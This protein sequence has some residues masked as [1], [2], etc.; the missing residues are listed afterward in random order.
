[1]G[2]Y[3]ARHLEALRNF[4][5]YSRRQQQQVHTL[6]ARSQQVRG[7]CWRG[8]QKYCLPLCV[9]DIS[10]VPNVPSASIPRWEERC[11]YVDILPRI[12]MQLGGKWGQKAGY[13]AFISR[14][15][16][17]CRRPYIWGLAPLQLPNAL[18][19]PRALCAGGRVMEMDNQGMTATSSPLPSSDH[20]ARPWRA[21]RTCLSAVVESA[22]DVSV[23]HLIMPSTDA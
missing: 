21:A 1:M 15:A 19:P 14:A 2:G 12:C 11:L 23:V 4:E 8:R 10:L 18:L 17:V 22:F 6:R 9:C 20:V 16:V 7:A 13:L 3:G 5:N